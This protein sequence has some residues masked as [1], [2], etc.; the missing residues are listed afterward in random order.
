MIIIE[1]EK[2]IKLEIVYFETGKPNSS[3]DK[4]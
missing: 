2:N 4:H 1:L 3:Q